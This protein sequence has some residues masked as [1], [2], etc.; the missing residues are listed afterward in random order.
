MA[1]VVK[2]SYVTVREPDMY[3]GLQADYNK[4]AEE[5]VRETAKRIDVVR[6]S[7]GDLTK[8]FHD[9]LADLARARQQFAIDHKTENAENFGVRRD[10]E[11]PH[12]CFNTELSCPYEEYNEKLVLRMQYELQPIKRT[13]RTI[14]QTT[15]KIE[16]KPFL[17]RASSTTYEIMVAEKSATLPPPFAESEYHRICKICSIEPQRGPY[18]SN[19][20]NQII[21]DKSLLKVLKEASIE[22]YKLVRWL[23]MVVRLREK[24]PEERKSDWVTGTVRIQIGDKMYALTQYFTWLYRTCSN[25]PIE[26]MTLK[27]RVALIHQDLFLIEPTLQ[28]IAKIF[29]R[30]VEW[31]GKEI[32]RLQQDVAELEYLFSHCAPFARGSMAISEWIEMAIYESHGFEIKYKLPVNLEALTLPFQEFVE[33]YPSMVDVQKKSSQ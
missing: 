4:R 5:T 12:Y 20:F 32:S 10:G 14:D 28:E 18:S 2:Q 29:K 33:K 3:G 26:R 11:S 13:L 15:L 30:A 22:D 21:K 16:G 31:D 17:G 27:S 7:K 24:Y 6:E 8:L 1:A 25:D 19:F 9:I 23:I